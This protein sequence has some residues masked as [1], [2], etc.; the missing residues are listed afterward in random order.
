MEAIAQ[1]ATAVTASSPQSGTPGD[2]Q[3]KPRNRSHDI[4]AALRGE[5]LDNNAFLTAFFNGMSIAFPVGEKFFIDS[6]RHYADQITDPVLKEQIK[7][8]CG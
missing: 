6:V 2:V 4:S 7:G 1:S 8:F 5:W 3:I